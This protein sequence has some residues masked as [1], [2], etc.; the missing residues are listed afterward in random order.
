ML[1]DALSLP[2]PPPFDAMTEDEVMR[3]VN[4]EIANAR[5]KGAGRLKTE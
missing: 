3:T 5:A 2:A 4:E 1:K